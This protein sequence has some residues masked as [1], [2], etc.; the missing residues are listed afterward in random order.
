MNR[1]LSLSL[2]LAFT[3]CVDTVDDPNLETDEEAVFGT[4]TVFAR[5][6]DPGFP[7]GLGV[8]GDRVFTSTA[9]SIHPTAGTGP[10]E[11]KIYD[12]VTGNHRR[13]QAL[14]GQ[15]LTQDH[16][17]AA[18]AFDADGRLYQIDTQRGIRRFN[19]LVT[20]ESAYTGPFPNLPTCAASAPPCSPTAT[21]MP[22][23]PNDL[24]FGGDGSL[25]V[26]D[27]NQA[28]IWRVPPGGGT[29]VVWFQDAR[30]GDL[31]AGPNGIRIDPTLTWVYFN[32][33][34]ASS[35]A[36]A[37][38][39]RLPL[40]AAPSA[41]DLTLVHAYGPF[42]FP[43]G[44]AIGEAGDLYVALG[45]VNQISVLDSSGAEITR[46]AGVATDPNG[47]LPVAFDAPANIAFLPLRRSILFTNAAQLGPSTDWAL[48]K[49][50]VD[51]AGAT[52]YRPTVP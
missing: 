2:L 22:A 45:L 11:I 36:P 42:E 17:V 33:T 18:M 4:A 31:Q 34:M 35:T 8:S 12:R 40:V 52:I 9:G 20:T 15:D 44:I 46:L 14:V 23:F 50:F 48:I 7:E 24:A 49:V 41:A 1:Y 13:D 25:Y 51:D 27:T 43:D 10:S 39:W 6:D 16:T 37:G 29:P 26:T 28:T 3:G 32:T 38:T 19:A 21:D 5:V 47:G 30:I